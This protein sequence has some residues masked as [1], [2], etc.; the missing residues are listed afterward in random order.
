MN[1]KSIYGTKIITTIMAVAL[2]MCSMLALTG[3]GEDSDK[4]INIDFDA[5][6]NLNGSKDD[7]D[8]GF[9]NNWSDNWGGSD[10]DD[11][12]SQNKPDGDTTADIDNKNH[13]DNKTDEKFEYYSNLPISMI[14]P[15]NYLEIFGKTFDEIINQY[16]ETRAFIYDEV[17]S[18]GYAAEIHYNIEDMYEDFKL[19]I[20]LNESMKAV[21]LNGRFP[22]NDTLGLPSMMSA[23]DDIGYE[24]HM[25]TNPLIT[26]YEPIDYYENFSF[27][28]E[29]YTFWGKSD[30]YEGESWFYGITLGGAKD[31]SIRSV[32]KKSPLCSPDSYYQH[33]FA[34]VTHDGIDDMIS[35]WTSGNRARIVVTDGSS[36][37]P[38]EIYSEDL[39]L[40]VKHDVLDY[41]GGES[42]NYLLYFEKGKAYL[43]RTGFVDIADPF[44]ELSIFHLNSDGT[45]ESRY[46]EYYGY[47]TNN[48]SGD[49]TKA[50]HRHKE[51]CKT[52]FYLLESVSGIRYYAS[53]ISDA[54]IAK[55]KNN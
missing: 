3:C 18:E 24:Y 15:M 29:E 27:T 17:S 32:F 34:D 23:F 31:D 7:N 9:D 4:D 44:G 51:L 48:S 2:V 35:V 26:S 54:D 53:S 14:A 40:E 46:Y 30:E 52:S 22:I 6:E 16:G 49:W 36:G 10:D 50:T 20:L 47:K 19:D 1:R 5:F 45:K 43:F 21:A 38:K 37:E 11:Q 12:S 42:P 8:S 13:D 39:K 55:M 41:L 25:K 28:T 33:T